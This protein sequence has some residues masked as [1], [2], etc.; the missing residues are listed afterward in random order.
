MEATFQLTRRGTAQ[1]TVRAAPFLRRRHGGC[2]TGQSACGRVQTAVD[3]GVGYGERQL[4]AH[5]RARTLLAPWCPGE[6]APSACA[7]KQVNDM[8]KHRHL[9][10]LSL[11]VGLLVTT[12]SAAPG[13]STAA[14]GQST[15]AAGQSNTAAGQSNTSGS[16]FSS[17]FNSPF[18]AAAEQS[19][20]A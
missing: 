8:S 15:A 16:P 9:P 7:G 17:P 19:N 10:H 11:L 3:R 14:A 20:T 5:H 2:G 13:Q 18:N 4:R 12:A 1:S 6:T